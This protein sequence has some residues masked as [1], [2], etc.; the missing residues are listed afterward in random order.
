MAPDDLLALGAIGGREFA[1]ALA[2]TTQTLVC[3]LDRDGRILLFNDACERATGFSREEALGADARD[4][5]IPR[6][7]QEAFGEMLAGVWATGHP[8]P[9]VGHWE[10]ADGRRRLIAWS[11][12]PVLDDTGTPLY[13]VTSGLDLTERDPRNGDALAGDLDAKLAELGRLA[14]EQRALRRVATLVASEATPDRVFAAVSEE[15]ARV[16]D[17]EASAVFRYEGDDTA[18]MV[19]QYA[20]SGDSIFGLGARLPVEGASAIGRVLF[21]GA[22]ARID[23][24]SGLRGTLARRMTS[25]GYRSTVAAPIF[26]RGVLW[27]S[28]TITSPDVLPPDCEV[29]LGNFCELVSLAVASAQAREDLL[30]SRSRLVSAGDTQRQR[31]ERNLHDGAQQHLVALSVTLRLARAKLQSAPAEVVPLLEGASRELDDALDELRELAR[32]LH[33]VLL[34]DRGLRQALHA[35]AERLPLRV[36]IEAPEERFP[37]S[38]EATAYYIATEAL[39]NVAKHAGANGASVVVSRD[40]AGLRLEISDDGVGGADPAS[41]S[42]I[43]GLRDRAE[44]AG[45]TLLV[46]SPPGRGTRVEATLPVTP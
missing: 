40:E 18:T 44:A 23:D 32:G 38:V 1:A 33:P 20:R 8:S 39:T 35:L 19:G 26:V 17:G 7:E 22:P 13:L 11:N 14:Q 29:R 15:C 42:G 37:A 16:V 6:E 34:T 12:R 9:Q 2:E 43:L 30:A 28:V 41:G 27:G 5:V 4:L 24:Y 31:L 36:G 3:V 46:I 10:T 45:G 25:R 21:T